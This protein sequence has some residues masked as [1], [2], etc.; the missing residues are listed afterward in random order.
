[1]HG[2]VMMLTVYS[3]VLPS[4][5]CGMFKKLEPSCKHEE[6]AQQQTSVSDSTTND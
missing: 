2:P 1:M 4:D 6:E 5:Q 3:S